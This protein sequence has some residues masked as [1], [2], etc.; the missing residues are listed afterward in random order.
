M[1]RSLVVRGTATVPLDSLARPDDRYLRPR[2]VDAA[3]TG[4]YRLGR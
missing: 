4:F 3:C 2:A 1:D